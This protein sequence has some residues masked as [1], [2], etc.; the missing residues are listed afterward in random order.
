MPTEFS[1]H[2]HICIYMYALLP[3]IFSI[4]SLYVYM[5][6]YIGGDV[7]NKPDH[8][9]FEDQYVYSY[10]A[11]SRSSLDSEYIAGAALLSLAN[12]MD[13]LGRSRVGV[14]KA[15]GVCKMGSCIY[16]SY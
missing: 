9:H 2:S 15:K 12:S 5:Y 13:K 11:R 7:V 16:S 10:G 4:V 3:S 14:W 6:V 1:Q 8:Y